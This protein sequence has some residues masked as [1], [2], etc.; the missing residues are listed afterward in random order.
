M[1]LIEAGGRTIAYH[2]AGH[3][4]PLLLLH[5]G[6]GD[7][8]DWGRQLGGLSDEFDVVAWDAPGCGGSDDPPA[9]MTMADYAD[10]AA[11]LVAAL[12]L[13]RPHVCG[14][15]FG[16]G[17][18]LA[19]YRHHPH[20]VR[21]LVLAGAYAGWKGSLPPAEVRARLERVRA[22]IAQPPAGWVDGYLPGF[23]A[24]PVPP[25]TIELV[26]SIMLD[27]R[28][29]GVLP[30]LT[31]FAEADLRDVLPTIAVP[32]L[33]LYGDADARAPRPVAEALHAA[34]PGAELVWLP[35]VGHAANLEA[36]AAF[37]AE[38]RRFLRTAG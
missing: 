3:G 24:G 15:S 6:F 31:A 17:L 19:V 35:G 9:V 4:P 22:E 1:A 5:G 8:R 28:P 14:L 29:A 10:A 33:L 25:E 7:G 12:G 30:M 18:A 20:L 37:D 34:V 13:D 11:D 26:R 27:V 2:R 21:S 36:P 38:V 23:F 32:T 16:A